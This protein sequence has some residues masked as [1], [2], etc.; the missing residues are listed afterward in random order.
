MITTLRE[1]GTHAAAYVSIGYAYPGSWYAK[2]FKS[3]DAG[4][5]YFYR[6]DSAFNCIDGTEFGPYLMGPAAFDAAR[7]AHPGLPIAPGCVGWINE[8]LSRPAPKLRGMKIADKG[9]NP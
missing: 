1:K 3:A 9:I 4:C 2:H 5:W 6:L 8:M 7:V